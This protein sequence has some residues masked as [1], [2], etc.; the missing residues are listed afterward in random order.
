METK[1]RYADLRE[2]P[3][4]INLFFDRVGPWFYSFYFTAIGYRASL[5]YLIRAN[6]DLLGLKEGMRILDAGIGTGF[7]TV[8]LL[9][10][11]SEPLEV[12]GLDFSPG[13]LLGLNRRL[14]RLGLERRV[15][16]H[17]ADMRQMP[18]ADASF[19]LVIT[20]AAMEYLPE[21]WEGISECG[22]VLRP[23]GKLL[24]IATRNSLMGK[25]IAATW[26]NKVLEP[27]HVIR[28]MNQAGITAIETLRFPWYFP[29]VNSWGMV[30]LGC[31]D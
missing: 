1:H 24:F 23:G 18:F 9:R 22:R 29:H 12:F 20:S 13:M 21:V 15:R 10:E 3:A 5:K 14:T 28:G 27:A 6:L 4:S 30:L 31:K 11:A 16:L 26:R 8:N 25:M 2:S 17:L 7:L 19:D